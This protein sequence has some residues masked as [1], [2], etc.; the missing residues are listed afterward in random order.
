MAIQPDQEEPV[1]TPKIIDHET[2]QLLLAAISHRQTVLVATA[3]DL[4]RQAHE[5]EAEPAVAAKLR[6]RAEVYAERASQLRQLWNDAKPVDV[7]VTL[8][9]ERNL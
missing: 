5:A 3:N 6:E 4:Y 2:K 7:R 9:R 1:T 8:T